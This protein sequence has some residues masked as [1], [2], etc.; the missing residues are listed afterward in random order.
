[1]PSDVLESLHELGLRHGTD[2][3][4]PGR[5]LLWHY[6]RFLAHLREDD[7]VLIEIGVKGGA[8]LRM[9]RDYFASGRI[10]GID[11][12]P[13][14]AQHAEDRVSVRIGSAADPALLDEVLA[15]SGPP[16]V[17][18]DDGSHRVRDQIG[19]LRHLW[20][21]VK[22]GGL[23]IVEDIHTSYLPDYN[24]RWREPGTT[25][26]LLKGVVDDMHARWHDRPVLLLQDCVMVN[27]VEQACLL[28]KQA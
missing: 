3:A 4:N 1:L 22:P 16:D 17:V 13:E 11:I 18:I 19:T 9:W 6:E 24:M 25:V 20:P 2:K 14:S 15:E 26:E 12:N 5:A 10:F 28:L 23:Y 21:H 27:F 7:V 8:S